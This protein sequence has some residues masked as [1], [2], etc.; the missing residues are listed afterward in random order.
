MPIKIKTLYMV[1]KLESVECNSGCSIGTIHEFSC[2][3]TQISFGCPMS[4]PSFFPKIPAIL[5]AHPDKCSKLQN[6]IGNLG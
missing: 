3:K 2:V 4:D 6:A 1:F 5:A